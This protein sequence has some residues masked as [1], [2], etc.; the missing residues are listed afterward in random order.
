MMYYFVVRLNANLVEI[1]VSNFIFL[2]AIFAGALTAANPAIA[3]DAKLPNL[4]RI[5]VPF[6]PGGSNDV[7]ARAMAVPLAKRLETAVIVDNKPGASGVIG[8]DA[9]AKAPRDG[10]VL[11]LTSST[12][13]TVAATQAKL[14]YDALTGFA[15]VAMVA[16]GPLL[17]AVAA[18]M[19]MRSPADLLTAARVKPGVLTY[20]SAGIGSVGHMAT[21]LLNAAAK[22]Q[23]THVA[24]KGAA[25][26]IVDLAG[27]QINVMI[28]N[29]SS[30]VPQL[31]SGRVRALAVT[32]KQSSLVFPD[33]PTLAATVPGYSIDIWISVFAPAGTP[34]PLIERLNREIREISASAELRVFLE[35]DGALPVSIG[36]STLAA[37]LKEELAQWKAI[38]AER[39]IV[40]E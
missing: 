19:P 31:N 30:L 20:G 15:P 33:L 32:S 34:A 11:L 18:S 5:V 10:S 21:E 37:R 6:G 14:P 35:P 3:A 2:M 7:V 36:A 27:G 38:A 1:T 12:F 9:V 28:S 13:L 24:Y 17:L 26:A 8:N 25:N 22:I 16:E 40:T 39:K 4:V 29:Y 23:M